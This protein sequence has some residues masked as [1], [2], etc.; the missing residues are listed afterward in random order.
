MWRGAGRGL[1]W[2]DEDEAVRES[3]DEEARLL[4]EL[5][6]MHVLKQKS[7]AAMGGAVFSD[8]QDRHA[9]AKYE[10]SFMWTVTL[11][12]AST[13]TSTGFYQWGGTRPVDGAGGD[14]SQ[15]GGVISYDQAGVGVLFPS[16]A[17][18]R[19][20]IPSEARW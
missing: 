12:V 8:H 5:W 19:T 20:V 4:P 15:P 6:D 16:L 18:H 3:D 2:G 1:D 10:K 14:G 17:W 13:G 9:E 7:G 11:L